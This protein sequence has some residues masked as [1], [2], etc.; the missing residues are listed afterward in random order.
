M[1]RRGAADKLRRMH[2][3][4]PARPAT[5][6]WLL[7]AIALLLALLLVHPGRASADTGCDWNPDLC[8]PWEESMSATLTLQTPA[9]IRVTSDASALDCTGGC[10]KKA[11]YSVWCYPGE[12]CGDYVYD[13]YTLTVANPPAGWGPVWSGCDWVLDGRCGLT[14]DANR[15]V[16]LSWTDIGAPTVAF[17]PPAKA[18][19]S[20]ALV[21]TGADNSGSF[22]YDWTVD[23]AAQT[24]HG[25]SLTLSAFGEG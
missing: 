8:S 16:S 6:R 15:T 3:I 10:T 23:G 18:G 24:W 12:G 14:L 22:V 1:R 17:S 21:A 11:T 7:A 4:L 20:T 19:G 13:E 5:L 9:G 25:P 2:S